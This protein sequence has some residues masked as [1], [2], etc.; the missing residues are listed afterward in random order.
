MSHAARRCTARRRRASGSTR[1]ARTVKRTVTS[2][3][4]EPAV[5]TLTGDMCRAGSETRIDGRCMTV[6]SSRMCRI[7]L[8]R[9]TSSTGCVD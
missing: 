5:G 3:G 7:R 4:R 8:L 2:M 1:R 6:G 9:V